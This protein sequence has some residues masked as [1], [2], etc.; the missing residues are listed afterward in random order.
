[1]FAGINVSA[2][3]VKLGC[4]AAI[5]T[6]TVRPTEVCVNTNAIRDECRKAPNT[7]FCSGIEYK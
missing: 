3:E 5:V 4:A 6:G 1:M 7:V 2:L